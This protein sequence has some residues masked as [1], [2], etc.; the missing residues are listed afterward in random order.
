MQVKS[1]LRRKLLQQRK[2]IDKETLGKISEQIT[3]NLLSVNEFI[4]ASQIFCYVSLSHEFFTFGIM[5]YCLKNRKKLAVPL[6]VGESM[7]F[8]Y[9]NDFSDLEPGSFSVMEPRSYC[10]AAV[11]DEKTVCITPALCCN[12]EKFRIGYG[13]GYYDRFFQKNKCV[14]IGLC[15]EEFICDFK[16]DPN[17]IAVDMIVTEKCV[18]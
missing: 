11:A 17:D 3:R 14:K 15:S 6:C 7:E 1:E 8:R 13:K 2:A 5:E 16:Q 4:N 9:I 18:R 12:G 10:K